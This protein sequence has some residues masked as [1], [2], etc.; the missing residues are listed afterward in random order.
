[1]DSRKIRGGFTLVELLVVIAI[2]G[3]LVA[4]LLPAVQAAR[5]AARRMTCGNNLKQLG[6]AVHNYHDTYTKF[7]FGVQRDFKFPNGQPSWNTN[8]LTWMVRVL[9]YME[10]K[11]LHNKV[12]Y[13]LHPGNGGVNRPIRGRY[14]QV[15]ICPS[16]RPDYRVTQTYGPTNYVACVGWR[17]NTIWNPADKRRGIFGVNNRIS[18]NGIKDGS[19]TTLMLSECKINDPWVRRYG[20]NTSDYNRCLAGTAPDIN[21]NVSGDSTSRGWSWFFG[22]RNQSWSFNTLFTPN[23]QIRGYHECEQWTTTGVFGARSRHPGGVEAT[24]GDASV[25]FYS[26]LIDR[27]VWLD[28]GTSNGREVIRSID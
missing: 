15:H 8:M 3:I 16:D 24:N 17:Q 21:S 12:D 10:N 2:I 1:M 25:R 11:A 18:I 7:P 22:Q 6:L 14:L 28:L 20:T 13:S 9:P 4:L 5:E 27:K 19:S 26:D 23:D